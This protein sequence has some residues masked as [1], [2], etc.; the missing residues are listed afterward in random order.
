MPTLAR[1]RLCGAI[2]RSRRMK[3]FRCTILFLVCTLGTGCITPS[4]R[5]RV[6]TIPHRQLPLRATFSVRVSSSTPS[7]T[8]ATIARSVAQCMESAGYTRSDAPELADLEVTYSFSI[9]AGEQ[10]ISS[11]PDFVV[12]GHSVHSATLY[13]R[14]FQIAIIALQTPHLPDKPDVVW[15][16]EVFSEGS[17]VD[18]S[19]IGPYFIEQI[20][21]NLGREVTNQPFRVKMR[22]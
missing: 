18:L 6:S 15:Q 12:G 10:V 8:E 9:G 1:R 17:T 4:I 5:G 14:L 16:G 20:C 2:S 11:S 21:S 13:P 22:R 7:V 3:I 19:V